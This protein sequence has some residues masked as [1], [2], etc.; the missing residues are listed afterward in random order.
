MDLIEAE[1]WVIEEEKVRVEDN[2]DCVKRKSV[3][4]RFGSKLK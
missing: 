1:I 3:A 4:S 2:Y